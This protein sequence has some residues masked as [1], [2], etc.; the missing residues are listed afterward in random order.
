MIRGWRALGLVI[1]TIA[2]VLVVAPDAG[3]GSISQTQSAIV[4]LSDQ[5]ARQAR[6]S[7]ITANQYDSARVRPAAIA[8][9]IEHLQ[10]RAAISLVAAQ[11][12]AAA[13]RAAVVHAYVLGVPNVQILALL[14][15]NTTVGDARK[16]FEDVAIGNLYQFQRHSRISPTDGR[17]RSQ[18]RSTRRQAQ[19]SDWRATSNCGGVRRRRAGR[20]QCGDR[21]R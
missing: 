19:R 5:L 1:L 14:N 16:I 2:G 21:G 11:S 8:A 18:A 20:G 7:E 10:L 12:A 15:Q 9:N 4:R 13:L 6:T 3:A 17:L